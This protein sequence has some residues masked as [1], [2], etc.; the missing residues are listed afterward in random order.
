MSLDHKSTAYSHGFFRILSGVGTFAS[1][2][3]QH[4]AKSPLPQGFVVSFACAIPF[5]EA[6]LGLALIAG[7][8][9]RLSL[10]LGAVFMMA[11]TIGV[12]SNQQWDT[13]GQQLLYSVVFFLLL[14][15]LE[16]NAL[17]LDTLRRPHPTVDPELPN[18]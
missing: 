3:A 12:S 2:T 13:A 9:T 7:L 5:L 11:L 18:V 8:L 14:F 4:L 1:T 15:F 6:A 16:Y 10:I 17:A